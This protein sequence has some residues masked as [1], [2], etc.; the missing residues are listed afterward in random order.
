MDILR[1]AMLIPLQPGVYESA[2]LYDVG[3]VRIVAGLHKPERQLVPSALGRAQQRAVE[4]AAC[5]AT[6]V[7]LL[8]YQRLRIVKRSALIRPT[9]VVRLV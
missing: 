9:V 2:T 1:R 7:A 8:C 5:S 3:Y 4:V 6:P